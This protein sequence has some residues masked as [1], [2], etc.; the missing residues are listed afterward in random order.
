MY[1]IY[2]LVPSEK[3][4]GKTDKIPLSPATGLPVSINDSGHWVDRMM[5]DMACKIHKAD[6][7][8]MVITPGYFFIDVDGCLDGNTYSPLALEMLRT[9]K[10]C[11]REISSSRRGLHFIG[12]GTAPPHLCRNDALHIEF[13]TE[14]RFCALT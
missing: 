13:Y 9:F 11:Y 2:K 8:G 7:V 10:H 1:I 12:R 5:A 14:G 3:R 6:G 4:V